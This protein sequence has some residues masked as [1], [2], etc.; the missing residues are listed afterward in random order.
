MASAPDHGSVDQRADTDASVDR[1]VAAPSPIDPELLRILA[2]YM[3]EA[4]S[5]VAP[6]ATITA[7]LGPPDGLLGYGSQTG[8]SAFLYAHP[9]DVPELVALGHEVAG[10]PAGT[11]AR[12]LCRMKHA[13][14]T[15]RQLEVLSVNMT[16]DPRVGGLI[17]RTREAIGT[18]SHPESSRAPE[19]RPMLE[20]LADMAPAP[21]LMV[22]PVGHVHFANAAALELLGLD[23]PTIQ[24]MKI[25]DL[26]DD[27]S[28]KLLRDVMAELNGQSARR[29]LTLTL[30]GR[31]TND[32]RRIVRA[33]IDARRSS[34]DLSVMCVSLED[35]TAQHERE[36]RLVAQAARD[37]LTG[38]LNRSE[39]IRIIEEDLDSKPESVVIAY[40]DLDGFKAVND[41]LGHAAGDDMLVGMATSLSG[42][43]R[44]E[45]VL[46]R[47]GGDEFVFV[48]L[49]ID[50]TAAAAFASRVMVQ[51][52]KRLASGNPAAIAASIGLARGR[53]GD[54]ARDLLDRADRAMYA[55]KTIRRS[56]GGMADSDPS[57]F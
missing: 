33:D 50:D 11:E 25:F 46:G 20:S 34:V 39:V 56:G 17:V 21:I 29:S 22:G 2:G 32:D 9:D 27:D 38:L 28:A 24:G 40:C 5:V 7:S 51:I 19:G 10:G 55:A 44:R 6:D 15:W 57:G 12:Y 16:D 54:T 3:T 14:G 43:C 49:G 1:G 31:R 8:Q 41:K 30:K 23:L 53:A 52:D 18:A 42:M 45:D 48:L 13:D 37:P 36:Q 4:I 26:A 35:V 47:I